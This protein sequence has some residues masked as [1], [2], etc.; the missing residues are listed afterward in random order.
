MR[1]RKA[2]STTIPHS[3]GFPVEA[4]YQVF[5]SVV[6]RLVASRSKVQR[7]KC[8]N[9]MYD[10]TVTLVVIRYLKRLGREGGICSS[11]SQKRTNTSPVC[12]KRSSVTLGVLLK[13]PGPACHVVTNLIGFDLHYYIVISREFRAAACKG[14]C[15]SRT[16]MA[17]LR[18]V[19][20]QQ[21]SLPL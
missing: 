19:V 4:R 10:D 8:C 1:S 18:I 20:L 21:R 12:R 15:C 5:A 6:K 2:S 13:Y 7:R 3:W 14:R 16:P 17:T 11:E 9:S